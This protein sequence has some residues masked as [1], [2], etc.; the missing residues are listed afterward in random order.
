MFYRAALLCK[1]LFLRGLADCLRRGVSHYQ[2]VCVQYSVLYELFY[3]SCTVHISRYI[4][5]RDVSGMLDDA[6][7]MTRKTRLWRLKENVHGI[8]FFYLFLKYR[9]KR[10]ELEVFQR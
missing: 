7:F 1:H 8:C 3:C 4:Q 2:S 6:G 5:N 9:R 10:C